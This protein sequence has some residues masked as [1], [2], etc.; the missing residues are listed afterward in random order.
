MNRL[1]NLSSAT[2]LAMAAGLCIVAQPALAAGAPDE[3][4]MDVVSQDGN[5]Q[6]GNLDNGNVDDDAMDDNDD[7]E[8]GEVGNHEAG[9]A[10]EDASP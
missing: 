1:M 5:A 6:D 4:T 9:D 2:F 7:G 8:M 3:V 10:H